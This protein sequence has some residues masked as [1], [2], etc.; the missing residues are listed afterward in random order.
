MGRKI[1]GWSEGDGKLA[2]ISSGGLE[3]VQQPITTGRGLGDLPKSW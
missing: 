3:L 1:M 2:I